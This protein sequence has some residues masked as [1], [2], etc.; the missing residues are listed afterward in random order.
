[1][2]DCRILLRG[3][4][5]IRLHNTEISSDQHKDVRND[6]DQRQDQKRRYGGASSDE[7]DEAPAEH[8]HPRLYTGL[9]VT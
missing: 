5:L 8:S 2:T 4:I 9:R 1:M 6:D 3:C 7:P